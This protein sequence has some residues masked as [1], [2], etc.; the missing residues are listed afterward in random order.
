[1]PSASPSLAP[2]PADALRLQLQAKDGE[3][4]ISVKPDTTPVVQALL[5]PGESREFVASSKV[6]LT[7]GNL[8]SASLK[9]NGRDAKIP[10]QGN[11]TVAKNVVITKDN[12]QTFFQ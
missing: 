12:L 7:V 9:I 3:V 10:G 6:V 4:W 8:P 2:V 5:K 11:G 1:T